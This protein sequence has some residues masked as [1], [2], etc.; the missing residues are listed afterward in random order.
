MLE[1]PRVGR[2]TLVLLQGSRLKSEYR[3][4]QKILVLWAPRAT[5]PSSQ[6]IITLHI[7]THFS[8]FELS[9]K[10]HKKIHSSEQL[11]EELREMMCPHLSQRNKRGSDRRSWGWETKGGGIQNYR[12]SGRE[13]VC[14]Q[15][16][17]G[18]MQ[19]GLRRRHPPGN[20]PEQ[21]ED[22]ERSLQRMSGGPA[23]TKRQ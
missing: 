6:L 11:C 10:S 14:I 17:A 16:T 8:Y 21:L 4:R 7:I 22:G 3:P 15:V 5:T 1:L 12:H 23:L 13:A 20:T 2:R 9:I 18:Q 19:W